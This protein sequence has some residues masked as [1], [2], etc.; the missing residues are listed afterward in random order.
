[1]PL[2]GFF[3]HHIRAGRPPQGVH[4]V[5]IPPP[6]ADPDLLVFVYGARSIVLARVTDNQLDGSN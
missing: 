2:A 1:M 5:S 6:A 3:A 4:S